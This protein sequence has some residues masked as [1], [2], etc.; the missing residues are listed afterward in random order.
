MRRVVLDAAVIGRVVRWRDDD[1]I[2]LAAVAPA[3]VHKDG[4]RHARRRRVFATRRDERFHAVGGEHF[5][6]AF[7]CGLR[8]RVGIN[9]YVNRPIHTHLAAVFADRLHHCQHVGFVERAIERR[10]TMA[11]GAEDDALLGYRRVRLQV[12]IGGQQLRKVDKRAVRGRLA[13]EGADVG[14]HRWVS[15]L[16]APQAPWS[17]I[18]G[19][20]SYRGCQACVHVAVRTSPQA[21][22]SFENSSMSPAAAA[23]Y[24]GSV[25]SAPTGAA[26]RCTRK[27]RH[28]WPGAA[29]AWRSISAG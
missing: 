16:W 26:A 8:Q 12:H 19:T 4:V 1:A 25:R 14:T 13:S 15:L 24:R 28:R 20:V 22:R 18:L 21:S 9:T 11:R 29:C 3:V 17:G 23:G 6:R 2:G 7:E 27:S 10:A 5:E